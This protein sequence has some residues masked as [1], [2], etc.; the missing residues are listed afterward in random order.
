MFFLGIIDCIQI[1][2]GGFYCGY[3][4]AVGMVYC[5]APTM[6]YILGCLAFG[7]WGSGSVTCVLLAINRCIDLI[8][9]ELGHTLFSGKKTLIWLLIPVSYFYYFSCVHTAI[10]FNSNLYAFFFDPFLGTPERHGLFDSEHVR[11][12]IF[13]LNISIL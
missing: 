10:I 8:N 12:F 2:I 1:P 11:E 5:M 13:C 6:N 3:S 7:C 9:P 4:A